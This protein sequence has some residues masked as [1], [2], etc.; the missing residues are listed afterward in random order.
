MRYLD[1]TSGRFLTEDPA[2]DGLNWFSY[3]G[4]NPV[5]FTD[6]WGMYTLKD[7]ALYIEINN[8]DV[9][10]MIK[11]D[12]KNY[13]YNISRDAENWIAGQAGYDPVT[14]KEY[15]GHVV[16]FAFYEYSE[17]K[18]APENSQSLALNGIRDGWSGEYDGKAHRVIMVNVNATNNI[19]LKKHQSFQIDV[20][21][22]KGISNVSGNTMQQK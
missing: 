6:P 3:C 19:V 7:T 18:S 22:G 5:K 13:K 14:S 16:T 2:K 20:R 1:P 10:A 11:E 15:D 9:K 21:A 4:G 12:P 17:D 8:I